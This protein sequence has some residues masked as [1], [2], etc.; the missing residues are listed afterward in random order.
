MRRFTVLALNKELGSLIAARYAAIEVEGE[1]AQLQVPAS[2]HAY[3]TLRDSADGARKQ[4]S[5]LACVAWADTWR[6]LSV[7]PKQGDK[8]VCRG[9]LSV[10]EDRGVYQLY[11]N[12]IQPAGQGDL[13]RQIAERI[14]RLSADGL[15]DPGRK[16]PLPSHPAVVGVAT[17]LTGAALQDFLKVS[18]H[19]YPAARIL[20]AGCLVQGDTAPASVIRALD[21]LEE[22]GSADVLV[23][24]R[25]GGSKEDLLAFQDE[26]LARRIAACRVPVVSA[27]GHQVD[28][29]I[30]DLVADAVA[31][32]PTAAAM[33]VLPDGPAMRQ[34]VDETL[35]ALDRA[36]ARALRHRR[37]RVDALTERLRHPRERIAEAQR[38][39][40]ELRR[41]L[42]AAV[43]R[44]LSS[45]ARALSLVTPRLTPAA[46]NTLTASARR[47][48][49][50]EGRLLALS[51]RAVLGRGYAIVRGPTGVVTDPAQVADG[52]ALAVEVAHGTL[53]AVVR[54]R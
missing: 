41:R 42:D 18:R 47:L 3:F 5:Q 35:L 7:R 16:R 26:Q 20:V 19:R 17:S 22:E 12:D 15:L 36:V 10:Y 27:V 29:T 24:T 32:T 40:V 46:R 50:A 33:L 14:A 28:T 31:P 1:I 44:N 48:A 34:R 38:R 45:H 52:D 30:A 4:S 21:L 23:V 6:R 49:A 9:K 11:V 25:G 39:R 8:V 2:G 54:A 51:P 53:D 43:A 13:Q 37:E